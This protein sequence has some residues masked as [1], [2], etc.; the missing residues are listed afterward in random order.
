MAIGTVEN[1]SPE[2]TEDSKSSTQELE[3]ILNF[4]CQLWVIFTHFSQCNNTFYYER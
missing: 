2:I 3:N 1:L 4:P